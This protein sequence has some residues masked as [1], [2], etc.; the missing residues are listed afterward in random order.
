MYA[1]YRCSLSSLVVGMTFRCSIPFALSV[2]KHTTKKFSTNKFSDCISYQKTT[3][4]TCILLFVFFFFFV[5][6]FHPL[7]FRLVFF[8]CS[9]NLISSLLFFFLVSWDQMALEPPIRL[10]QTSYTY[11]VFNF[12]LNEE[13]AEEDPIQC[14]LPSWVSLLTPFG[15]SL[16]FA[17][18]LNTSFWVARNECDRIFSLS[19]PPYCFPFA[20]TD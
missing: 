14:M 15:L 3:M 6:C 17:F 7:Q 13:I 5:F 8:L 12:D 2:E 18:S 20:A 11:L 10:G 16:S 1:S 9:E 4:F 19:F